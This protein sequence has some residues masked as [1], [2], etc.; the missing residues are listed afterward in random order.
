MKEARLLSFHIAAHVGKPA[1][2]GASVRT[3]GGAVP[4]FSSPSPSTERGPGV[5]SKST[6]LMRLTKAASRRFLL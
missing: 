5:R 2:L 6:S 1:L 3:W 4:S